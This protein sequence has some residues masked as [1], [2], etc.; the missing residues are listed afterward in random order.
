MQRERLGNVDRTSVSDSPVFLNKL[1][2]FIYPSHFM[3]KSWTPLLKFW[4]QL[5]SYV[6]TLFL[7]FCKQHEEMKKG[8]SSDPLFLYSLI[9]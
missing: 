6:D 5:C 7:V 4:T 9:P 3:G 1:T 8:D 2:Y